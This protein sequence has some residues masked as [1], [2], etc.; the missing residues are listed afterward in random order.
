MGRNPEG[1]VSK[2]EHAS[3]KLNTDTV[4]LPGIQNNQQTFN[5]ISNTT[6]TASSNQDWLTVSPAIGSNNVTL[7]LTALE[8]SGISQRNAIVTVLSNGISKNIIVTQASI[9]SGLNPISEDDIQFYPIPVSDKLYIKFSKSL[10]ESTITIYSING[11]MLYSTKINSLNVDIDMSKF[12]LGLYY[13]K[14][15]TKEG[16]MLTKKIVK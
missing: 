9:I 7:T 14:I 1:G 8:N 6:W 12:A 16:N 5:V 13:A 3:I 2:L 4:H 15:I 10:S 11:N